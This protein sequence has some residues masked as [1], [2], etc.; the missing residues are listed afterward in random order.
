MRIV[1]PEAKTYM[2][3]PGICIYCD[4]EKTRDGP[5]GR[6]HI[7]AQRLGGQLILHKASCD[8]CANTIN[9]DF[10]RDVQQLMLS[11]VR[12]HLKLN[13]AKDRPK[14]LNLA[15]WPA[16]S[17][18]FAFPQDLADVDV[19]WDAIPTDDLPFRIILPRFGPP[20]VLWDAPKKRDF[21]IRVYKHDIYSDGKTTPPSSGE[22]SSEMQFFSPDRLLRLVAKIAHGA[23]SAE[24]FGKFKPMLPDVILGKSEHIS[25][26]V[27]SIGGRR[28][29]RPTLHE[30]TLTVRGGFLV[31]VVHLFAKFG[32]RPYVA[33][34]GKPDPELAKWHTSALIKSST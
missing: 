30:I 25:H 2:P 11:A 7:I 9:K 27:G 14:T 13:R 6:E 8:D 29:S 32:M 3:G 19:R 5:L 24:L 18:A 4:E 33:V 10:E 21:N 16:A 20:G 26:L 34:V 15:R 1:L 17:P 23:A 31:A 22:H 28:A 12:T